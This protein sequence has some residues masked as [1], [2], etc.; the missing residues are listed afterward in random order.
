MPDDGTDFAQLNGCPALNTS[1]ALT[2]VGPVHGITIL[3]WRFLQMRNSWWEKLTAEPEELRQVNKFYGLTVI[4]LVFIA[5]VFI[6]F[7]LLK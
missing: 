4:V 7:V 3:G 2:H 1:S 5:L 6:P